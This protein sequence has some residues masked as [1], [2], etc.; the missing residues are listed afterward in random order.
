MIRR[1]PTSYAGALLIAVACVAACGSATAAPRSGAAPATRPAKAMP[2]VQARSAHS[3]TVRFGEGRSSASF[4]LRQPE[5]VILLYRLRAPV[6]TRIHG[7]TQ[8]PSVSAPLSIGTT[9]EGPSST[10]KRTGETL[11]CAVG[12]EW[13][14]MPAGA[15]RVRLRKLVG[16]AGNVT[17][18]FRVGTPPRAT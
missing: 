4:R 8:L 13:C 2:A 17:L 3:V 12:E 15:W 9:E 6:G 16:P 5:G 18:V 10:C 11:I 7:V 1:R 14:P